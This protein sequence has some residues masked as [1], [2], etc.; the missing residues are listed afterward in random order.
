MAFIGVK[1]RSLFLLMSVFFISAC[2]QVDNT[3]EDG[4]LSTVHDYKIYVINK[5]QDILHLEYDENQYNYQNVFGRI[6]LIT[7]VYSHKK[8]IR[9][10][11]DSNTSSVMIEPDMNMSMSITHSEG[12]TMLNFI[13]AGTKENECNLHAAQRIEGSPR[14]LKVK[15]C[16]NMCASIVKPRD[17]DGF[18]FC[19]TLSD[20]DETGK[21]SSSSSSSRCVLPHEKW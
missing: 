4:D 2:G 3:N 15:N 19:V 5:S 12:L 16:Q 11:E 20:P 13:I 7:T 1:M 9:N 8:I 17:S 21:C 10:L 18:D 14:H 6:H